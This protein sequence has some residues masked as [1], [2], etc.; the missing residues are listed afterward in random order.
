VKTLAATHAHLRALWPSGWGWPLAPF[1]AYAAY[2]AARQDL[3]LEHLVIIAVVAALAYVGPRSKELLL[4]L[5]PFGLV[6]L[7]FDAMRP[8]RNLG[9]SESRVLV[10]ELRGWES[11]FFGW[12]SNGERFTLHDFFR[13]HH[14][15]AL[16]VFAAIPYATFI[17]WCVIGAVYL[18]RKDRPAMKRFAWGFLLLNV[19]GF[20]TY[21]L[22]PAAPPWYFHAKG[23][24]VDLAARASEGPA[25]AR[26]DELMG[27]HYFRGMYSKASSVFGALPSLH[28]AYPILLA[29][30]GWRVFGTR[31]RVLAVVYAASMIFAAVYLDHHWLIDACM[32]AAYAVIAALITRGASA[33]FARPRPLASLSEAS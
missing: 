4:G 1:V 21:H 27:F 33:L 25:L 18:Y 13:D 15:T 19:S 3:R 7:L 16:D 10:C 24:A 8:F 26:V 29:I 28:C 2:C 23:C 6:G 20:I 14:T 31:L 30:E 11:R 9:L 12:T 22:I 32:G 17:L 5:Y